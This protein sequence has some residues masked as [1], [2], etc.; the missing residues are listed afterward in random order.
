MEH[1]VSDVIDHL[2]GPVRNPPRLVVLLAGPYQCEL[3]EI[4]A[5]VPR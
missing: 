2:G 5:E 4:A 1:V 3:I